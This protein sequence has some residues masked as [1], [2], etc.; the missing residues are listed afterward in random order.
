MSEKIKPEKYINRYKD[1]FTFTPDEDGNV[2]WEGNFEY[3]RIGYND[4]REDITMVDPS[5]GPYL[6]VNMESTMAHSEIKNKKIV[7]FS[8][9]ENGYK[10]I[11]E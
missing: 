6:E 8:P 1:E 10:I 11:L 5:G 7:G 3:H 2:I 4:N 9:I